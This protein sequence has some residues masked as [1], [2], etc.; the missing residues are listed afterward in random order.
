[1]INK[2]KIQNFKN[3]RDQEIDLERLT[4]FVGANASGKTSVLEALHF[5]VRAA[6]GDPNKVFGYERHCD[7]LYTRGGTGHMSLTCT[8]G[9]GTLKLS[10]KPP[11]DFPPDRHELLGKGQWTFALSPDDKRER[12]TVHGSSR[13]RQVARGNGA[14]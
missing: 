13:I 10:A 12:R 6:T 14:W 3:I 1:M 11:A 2:I 7:W 4:V 8:T 5:A 9:T